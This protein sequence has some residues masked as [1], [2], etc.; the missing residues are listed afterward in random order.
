MDALKTE[1]QALLESKT[2]TNGPVSTRISDGVFSVWL[3]EPP[4]VFVSKNQWH[5]HLVQDPILD[6]RYTGSDW[7]VGLSRGIGR[8]ALS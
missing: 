2:A 7:D 8:T 5:S 1:D 4:G 6:R 3:F